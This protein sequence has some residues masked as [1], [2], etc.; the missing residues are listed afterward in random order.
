MRDTMPV[1]MSVRFGR[2]L[3]R[4]PEIPWAMISPHEARA[5]KNHSQSLEELARR[6]GLGALEALWILDEAG[7]DSSRMEEHVAM[8]ELER[9]IGDWYRAHPVKE[10][11]D[12]N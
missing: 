8:V 5:H 10:S 12:G 9:R 6:G 2:Y 4:K 7:W 11:T 1:L 3:S